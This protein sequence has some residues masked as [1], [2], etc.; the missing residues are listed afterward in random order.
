[1]TRARPPPSNDL[2]AGAAVADG[3]LSLAIASGLAR[4]YR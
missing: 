1:M 2:A 3:L 4:G